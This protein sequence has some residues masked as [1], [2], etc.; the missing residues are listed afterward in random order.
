[1][2]FTLHQP[3]HIYLI[4]DQIKFMMSGVWVTSIEILKK[5]SP[6]EVEEFGG[7]E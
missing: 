6:E 4:Y 2:R 5:I 7:E 3:K 1:M